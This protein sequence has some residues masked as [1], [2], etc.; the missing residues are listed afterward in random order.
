MRSNAIKKNAVRKCKVTRGKNGRPAIR[1]IVVAFVDLV[2]SRM[3]GLN[4]FSSRVIHSLEMNLD[5]ELFNVT[6]SQDVSPTL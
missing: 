2:E 3:Y 4:H 6:A 1:S 5:L